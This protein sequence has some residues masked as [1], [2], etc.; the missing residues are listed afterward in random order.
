[1]STT[2]TILIIFAVFLLLLLVTVIIVK[3]VS[4]RKNSELRS[5]VLKTSFIKNN[6]SGDKGNT[7]N[8]GNLL[9]NTDEGQMLT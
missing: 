7:D 3:I 2:A 8:D 9:Y 1:M 5:E 4:E 6:K